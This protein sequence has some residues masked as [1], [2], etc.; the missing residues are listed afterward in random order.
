MERVFPIR[1]N[2]LEDSPH[3]EG[4]HQKQEIEHQR[5]V[6]VETPQSE[7]SQASFRVP[8]HSPESGTT[9][10]SNDAYQNELPW[11][12][13]FLSPF[14]P[15][16]RSSAS[17]TSPLIYSEQCEYAFTDEHGHGVINAKRSTFTRCEDEPI[18]M[19]GAIQSHG[20]LVGL[21]MQEEAMV[22]RVVSEN[23]E[24]ICKY[25]PRRLLNTA[26]FLLVFPAHQ[27]LIFSSN[28]RCVKRR[29]QSTRQSV[30]PKIFSV[31]FIDPDGRLVPTWCAMHYISGAHTLLICEFEIQALDSPSIR[32][33]LGGD[34]PATPFASLPFG[35]LSSDPSDISS[36][37]TTKS[38][39]LH[40]TTDVFELFQGEGRTIEVLDVI[41]Q[42][43]QQLSSQETTQGLL[44]TIVGIVKELTGFHRC[45]IY[46]FDD[47]NNGEVVAEL[48]EPKAS[49]DSFRG[50]HFP[51]SDIPKQARDL[52]MISRVRVLFNIDHQPSRLICKS[53]A[54]LDVGLDLTHSYLRAMSPV[55]IKYLGNMG[56][57]ST[58]SVALQYN[59]KLWGLICC[60]SY[61]TFALRLPFP[62]RE[63][64]YWLG[65]SA[66]NCLDRL[67]NEEKNRARRNL[68][69]RQLKFD[70]QIWL[71]G[72]SEEFLR[73][74]GA[75][76]GFL[77]VQSE[78]RTIGKLSS[79]AEA[80]TL[81]RYV[82][83]RNFS[84]FFSTRNITADFPDLVYE[85]GFEHIAGL[86]VISLSREVGDFIL[87]FKT[88]Q[89]KE[90]HWAGK[91]NKI[92]AKDG[93]LEPRNSF[94][95]WTEV[96]RGTCKP[97]TD[98]SIEAA[99]I[100]KLI[101][102]NFIDLWREK[103]VTS[104]ESRM[105]RMLF[106]N[107]SHEVRTPLNHVVNCLELALEKPL[108]PSTREMLKTSH[109]ASKSL[110]YVIDDLFHL[111]GPQSPAPPPVSASFDLHKAMDSTL[112]QLKVHALQKPLR[113][114][115]VKDLDF[116]KY[117]IGDLQR[118]QRAV[119]TLVENAI[120]FTDQGG[121]TIHLGVLSSAA[122]NCII[123]ISIQDTGRGMAEKEL[124]ELFQDFEQVADETPD[125]TP[126]AIATEKGSGL[127][128]GLALL[129]RY[130]KHC[131]GQIR[132]TSA[133]GKG[134]LFSL[135]IPL[136]LVA[137]PSDIP[138]SLSRGST[139]SSGS[140]ISQRDTHGSR[141]PTI[142]NLRYQTNIEHVQQFPGSIRRHSEVPDAG[143]AGFQF[144]SP[145]ALNVGTPEMED[146]APKVVLIAD[147]NSVNLALLQKKLKKMGYEVQ[148]GRDGQQAFDLYQKCRNTVHFVLM[149][150]NMPIV[151]G[152]E[153][154]RMIRTIEGKCSTNASVSNSSDHTPK[155][156]SSVSLQ[157]PTEADPVSY[158][159]RRLPSFCE[160]ISLGSTVLSDVRTPESV[161]GDAESPAQSDD[162]PFIT[163]PA[164]PPPTTD[165]P[166]L[167]KRPPLFRPEQSYF[168]LHY[169]DPP[170]QSE[171]Q[172]SP[173]QREC[174][175]PA[176][177]NISTRFKPRVPIFAVSASLNLYTQE[178][179]AEAGFDG[180]L[181]KPVD[182]AR[183]GLVLRG[184]TDAGARAQAKY[185]CQDLKAGGWFE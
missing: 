4:N 93:R 29:F 7:I 12:S 69:A 66:S 177:P 48:V 105:K 43:Q 36:S 170:Q 96:V 30:E 98:E 46:R 74:F 47:E 14:P 21:E 163:R 59:N 156:P 129:A 145:S 182:F 113:F 175:S 172:V 158:V 51:S 71:T 78:A 115:V 72:S 60:H 39:P 41:S 91:P 10:G 109:T 173:F 102:G 32:R 24:A 133:H 84:T 37:F 143:R 99:A 16:S 97:W 151:G 107:L 5:V 157:V 76:F 124:E 141:R 132:G 116:P 6:L 179:L 50:L 54:D 176:I 70:P 185:Q 87:L 183:L 153:S 63:M 134:S 104:K 92:S 184:A 174:W 44:D 125:Q 166:P 68:I 108:D 148:A 106:L 161:N 38:Q 128:V 147:D 119:T 127:G 180:W 160:S 83:F 81:M 82:C 56:V 15:E 73:I 28:A 100:T 112:D 122:K 121:V 86:L 146:S 101:Y 167:L 171:S 95:K 11:P 64:C 89:I 135:E 77:V 75:D 20:M 114:E 94:K 110:I 88:S 58:L 181:Q 62:L 169:C 34:L 2:V 17:S 117:V 164:T 111:T 25:N 155:R 142:V 49:S 120:K 130:V 31:S 61:G 53:T 168:P 152:V 27:R 52:Y 67:L 85:P 126:E 103:E 35:P 40:V 150:L 8:T 137:D 178:G 57:R 19:P 90:V 154:T 33:P 26:N 22:C 136:C 144:I 23:S 65:L 149:D 138:V 13:N 139:S 79:Y 3:I 131:G 80:V 140:G 159:R 162:Q 9:P 123:L 118:L 165:C 18:Q 1:C 42:I 45:M 55:H